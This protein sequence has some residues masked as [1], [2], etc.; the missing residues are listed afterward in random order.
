MS[1]ILTLR[2]SDEIDNDV[3]VTPE[4]RIREITLEGTSTVIING[5][6]IKDLESTMT[7]LSLPK[8]VVCVLPRKSKLW[9]VMGDS[10]LEGIE[11]ME[12]GM[13]GLTDVASL[14]EVVS[15]MIGIPL[16]MFALSVKS[17]PGIQY[18]DKMTIGAYLYTYKKLSVHHMPYGFLPWALYQHNL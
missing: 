13:E 18:L 15:D 17:D 11:M 1:Y 16:G 3:T 8:L 4:T 9:I 12:L 6:I 7:D 2:S 10:D 14:Y 5:K